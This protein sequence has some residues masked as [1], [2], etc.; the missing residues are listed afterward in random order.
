MV[1]CIG[2]LGVTTVL[3]S[4]EVRA[5]VER[6]FSSVGRT[7]REYSVDIDLIALARS[8]DSALTVGVVPVIGHEAVV[9][10]CKQTILNS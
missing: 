5:D 1:V 4:H 8:L 6:E 2:K 10:N 9:V 7:A 3:I